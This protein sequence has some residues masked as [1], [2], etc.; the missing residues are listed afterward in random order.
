MSLH[1]RKHFAPTAPTGETNLPDHWPAGYTVE[2]S[3]SVPS[4]FTGNP[5]S[6]FSGGTAHRDPLI[7][8]AAGADDGATGCGKAI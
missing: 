2:D 4:T 8:R 6:A 7:R 3:P 1:N 5:V